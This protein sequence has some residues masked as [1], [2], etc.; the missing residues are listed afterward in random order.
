M[1]FTVAVPGTELLL[2]NHAIHTELLFEV[3]EYLLSPRLSVSNF[4][5]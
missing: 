5:F 4:T 1:S 3:V 2:P